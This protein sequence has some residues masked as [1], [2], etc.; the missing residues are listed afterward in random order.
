MYC[1]V[2]QHHTL[3]FTKLWTTQFF[4]LEVV[5]VSYFAIVMKSWLLHPAMHLISVFSRVL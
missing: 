3:E 2:Y 5:Q 1:D 4:Y